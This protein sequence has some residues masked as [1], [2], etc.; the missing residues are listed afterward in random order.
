[1]LIQP[2]WVYIKVHLPQVM[3]GKNI[4]QEISSVLSILITNVLFSIT[5]VELITKSH[6]LVQL[7]S[8]ISKI[9]F[10]KIIFRP[11]KGKEFLTF[12]TNWLH[13]LMAIL[14]IS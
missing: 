14:S 8:F 12:Y 7:T 13:L 11:L 1:M 10:S 3:L 4:R 6:S 5:L 9:N 2:F